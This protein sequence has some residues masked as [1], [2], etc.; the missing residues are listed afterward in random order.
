MT[1]P[2]HDEFEAWRADPVTEFVFA[3]LRA[4]AEAQAESFAGI[5]WTASPSAWDELRIT[6]ER[7]RTRAES[8]LELANIT[9][10]E[11]CVANGADPPPKPKEPA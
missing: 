5:A 2:S 10:G 9:L 3:G 8:Y 6:R 4:F 11:A 1:T 7:L